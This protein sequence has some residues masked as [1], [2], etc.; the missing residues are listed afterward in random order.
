MSEFTR[1]ANC[2][3]SEATSMTGS[4]FKD[5]HSVTGSVTRTLTRGVEIIASSDCTRMIDEAPSASH[6]P[7]TSLLPWPTICLLH[8][9]KSFASLAKFGRNAPPHSALT[10]NRQLATPHTPGDRCQQEMVSSSPSY[11]LAVPSS[12]LQTCP[13]GP[14]PK[15]PDQ[16]LNDR[17]N[18]GLF[19]TICDRYGCRL[20]DFDSSLRRRREARQE[21]RS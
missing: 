18:I 15:Y 4:Y 9:R 12:R 16:D 8:C 6:I 1:Q 7:E 11:R 17:N 20:R 5:T 14:L 2:T 10:V 13:N 21:K 3:R 19:E